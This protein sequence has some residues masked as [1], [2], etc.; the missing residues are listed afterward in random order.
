VLNNLTSYIQKENGFISIQGLPEGKYKLYLPSTE[1][2]LQHIVCNVIKT[3][4]QVP[5]RGIWSDWILGE[6]KYAKQNGSLLKK[7]LSI[8]ESI[9]TDKS[10]IFRLENW[11]SNAYAIVMTTT[12]VPHNDES[13]YARIVERRRRTYTEVFKNGMKSTRTLFLNDAHISEEYQ[14]ILK[15]AKSE[16]WVTSNLSKPTLLMYPKV[17]LSIGINKIVTV[18]L[19]FFYRKTLLQTL[20]LEIIGKNK[21]R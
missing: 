8:S 14:Y 4:A 12:F 11:S 7:P 9:V 13:N 2:G 16:K 17:N 3:Q 21:S 19:N 6:N 5:E 15:R 20:L 10:S 18:V 1:V